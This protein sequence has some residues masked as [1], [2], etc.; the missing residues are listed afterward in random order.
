VLDVFDLAHV[1]SPA[2]S[3]ADKSQSTK[4]QTTMNIS[5][6]NPYQSIA[7]ASVGV[8]TFIDPHVAHDATHA[9]VISR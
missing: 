2:I 9:E 7:P 6:K 1:F 3:H 8:P 4:L 5:I